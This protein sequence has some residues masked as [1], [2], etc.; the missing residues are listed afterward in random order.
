MQERPEPQE[1]GLLPR[2]REAVDWWLKKWG[3]QAVVDGK[4]PLTREDVERLIEVNGDT[5]EE[6]ELSWRDIRSINLEARLNSHKGEFQSF[7]LQGIK[8]FRANLQD[9]KLFNANLQ[10]AVLGYANLVGAALFEANLQNARLWFA[11]LQGA[12]LAMADLQ[13]ANLHGAELAGADFQWAKLQA[14]NLKAVQISSDTNLEGVEWDKDYIS[15]LERQG[16]YEAA[17]SVYRQLKESYDRTAMRGIA[18]K[19]HY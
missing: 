7:N 2:S 8:L 13:G 17:N 18:G 11:N 1:Q 14:T 12:G 9:A 3:R 16:D 10:N 5:A 6:L 19:F 15:F 4:E